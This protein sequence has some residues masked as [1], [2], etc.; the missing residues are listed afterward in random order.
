MEKAFLKVPASSHKNNVF[1]FPLGCFFTE[2]R[3]M[4]NK[5]RREDWGNGA[6]GGEKWKKEKAISSV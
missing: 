3:G 4:K 1:N 2:N 6:R 5:L